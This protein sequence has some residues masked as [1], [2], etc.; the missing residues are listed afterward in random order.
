VAAF[1]ATSMGVTVVARRDRMSELQRWL[2][3]LLL[4]AIGC[5]FALSYRFLTAGLLDEE[6]WLATV[7][8]LLGLGWPLWRFMRRA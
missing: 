5:M 7:A 4:G 2:A 3:T 1:V 8:F 6:K